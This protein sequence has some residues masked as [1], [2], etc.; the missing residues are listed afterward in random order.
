MWS[1]KIFKKL[2]SYLISAP[3]LFYLFYGVYKV[4]NKPMFVK[5]K[6]VMTPIL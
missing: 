5:N 1:I 4:V 2:I 6:I 3:A